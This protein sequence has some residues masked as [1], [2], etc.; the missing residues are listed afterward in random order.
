MKT[1]DR[2]PDSLAAY[3]WDCDFASLS[4]EG[5]RDFIIRRLLRYGSWEALTW[6]RLELGDAELR[7]WIEARRGAGLSPR[8]LRF[9]GLVLE[10]PR[11]KVTRWVHAAASRLWEGR[12]NG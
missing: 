10:V 11:A 8:Q 3:F 12:L 4:W 2:L 1:N 5:Q 9:W 6:L 7:R